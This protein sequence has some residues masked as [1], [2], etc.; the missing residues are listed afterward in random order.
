MR[1][2]YHHVE[3][4]D[5]DHSKDHREEESLNEPSNPCLFG[6]RRVVTLRGLT[7]VKLGRRVK[8]PKTTTGSGLDVGIK[9][10]GL[11]RV[12]FHGAPL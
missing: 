2:P 6:G 4:A 8:L 7:P 11:G 10:D 5:R 3:R 1:L 9:V 12:N